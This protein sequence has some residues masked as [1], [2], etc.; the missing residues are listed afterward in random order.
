MSPMRG[1]GG[2]GSIDI[3]VMVNFHRNK[4]WIYVHMIIVKIIGQNYLTKCRFTPD[5]RKN[6]RVGKI[7][8]V[9]CAYFTSI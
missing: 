8:D 6:T 4:Q 9:V 5:A 7:F 3:W 2:E 1:G